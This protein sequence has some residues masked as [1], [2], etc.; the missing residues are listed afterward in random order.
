MLLGIAE[1]Q[2]S[3]ELRKLRDHVTESHVL[4][5]LEYVITGHILYICCL[6]KLIFLISLMSAVQ[7]P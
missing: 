4:N 2:N 6:N 5:S 7:T 3:Q 1:P